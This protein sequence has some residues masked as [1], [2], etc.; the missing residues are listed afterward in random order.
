MTHIPP[1]MTRGRRILLDL[2]I[3]L[4][5]FAGMMEIFLDRSDGKH[6]A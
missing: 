3:P 2:I 1:I 6:E 5:A 4:L